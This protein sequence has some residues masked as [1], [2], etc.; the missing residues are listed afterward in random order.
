MFAVSGQGLK[1]AYTCGTYHRQ[2]LKGCTSHRVH[3]EVLD[4]TA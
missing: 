3:V 2:G 4:Q 1:P